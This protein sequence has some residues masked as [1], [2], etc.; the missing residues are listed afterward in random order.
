[1]DRGG[2]KVFAKITLVRTNAGVRLLTVYPYLKEFNVDG[3]PVV[4]FL[5]NGITHASYDIYNLLGDLM[6]FLDGHCGEVVT[7]YFKGFDYDKDIA[8]DCQGVMNEILNYFRLNIPGNRLVL[9]DS[10]TYKQLSKK[11]QQILIR[12]DSSSQNFSDSI[13]FDSRM[14]YGSLTEQLHKIAESYLAN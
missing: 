9:D 13:H 8:T 2:L 11:G 14:T 7:I 6:N 12:T 5:S 1:M 4:Q 3:T 10:L